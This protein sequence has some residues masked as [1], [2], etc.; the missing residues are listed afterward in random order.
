MTQVALAQPGAA[1]DPATLAG[2]AADLVPIE[3]SGASSGLLPLI[4]RTS[5]ALGP[6]AGLTVRQL[7][8]DRAS[9]RL[10]LDVA[11]ADE[12]VLARA[13]SSLA[14]AGLNPRRAPAAADGTGISARLTVGATA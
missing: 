7:S 2:T 1:I 8:F 10:G 13:V 11:A 3:G 9:G 5:V 12:A 14:A 4:N 6:A